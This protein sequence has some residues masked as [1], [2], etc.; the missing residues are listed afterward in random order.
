MAVK[1]TKTVFI[2]GCSK[3]GIGDA[4]AR[5]FHARGHVV[6]A[7]ARSADKMAELASLGI[8]TLELDVTS[9]SSIDAAVAAVRDTAGRLDILINNAGVLH[10]VPFAD[11][12]VADFRRVIETNVVGV[13]AVTHA[14]LPL[15]IKAKG[16][17]AGI[18]SINQVFNPPYLA[19]YNA[20]KAALTSLDHTM[21]I[22][23]APF[24]VRVVTVITGSVKSRLFENAVST[25]KLPEDSLYWP[26][27]ESIE[28]HS[29]LEGVKWTPADKYAKQV[30]SDLLKGKPRP[31]LWRAGL[32]T[33]ARVVSLFGWPGMLVSIDSLYFFLLSLS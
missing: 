10:S 1:E 7:T 15:L 16:V 25:T 23:L 21:R 18:G 12:S 24:G 8:K 6:F 11:C 2:T 14:L 22:E 19:A 31:V 26:L 4:L 27:R 13:F 17:V 32:S 29:L 28:T 5:E 20:S 33:I 3:G 30:V 9:A